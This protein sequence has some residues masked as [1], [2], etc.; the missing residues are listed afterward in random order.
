M[1]YEI[2][3]LIDKK[4]RSGRH[5]GFMK[6]GEFLWQYIRKVWRIAS[7]KKMRFRSGMSRWRTAES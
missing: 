1:E 7:R 2:V 4:S 6:N 3:R 5:S